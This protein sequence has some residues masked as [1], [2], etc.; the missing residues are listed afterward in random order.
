ILFFSN[1]RKNLDR[2]LKLASGKETEFFGLMQHL[3]GG[4]K[5]VK[6]N[7]VRS[8]NLYYN[9]IV[10]TAEELRNLK[11]KADRHFA[12]MSIIGQNFLYVLVAFIIFVLPA[13]GAADAQK[14][15]QL[16]TAIIFIMGP[17]GDV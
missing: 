10:T 3:L 15:V 11:L 9:Y 14:V 2:Q 4:F 17:L 16:A 1:T 12:S 5:E 8:D 13:F 6:M 7:R